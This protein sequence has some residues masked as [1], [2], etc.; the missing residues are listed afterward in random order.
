MG[1]NLK[2]GILCMDVSRPLNP[3]EFVA[4]AAIIGLLLAT[5]LS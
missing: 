5:V 2:Q 1:D 4:L 3:R